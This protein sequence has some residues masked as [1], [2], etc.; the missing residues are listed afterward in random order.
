ML[1]QH[2]HQLRVGDPCMRQFIG[3]HS[4][5]HNG[6]GSASQADEYFVH[7]VTG[8]S[9]STR[10][11]STLRAC[12]RVARTSAIPPITSRYDSARMSEILRSSPKAEGETSCAGAP[13]PATAPRQ[14]SRRASK[15]PGFSFRARTTLQDSCAELPTAPA[16]LAQFRFQDGCRRSCLELCSGA[17]QCSQLLM[18]A[19]H[20][21]C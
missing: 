1:C 19:S 7:S 3:S 16:A 13:A 12:K 2:T 6:L 15:A 10:N 11:Y 21:S 5:I 8:S 20:V 4:K 18:H 14:S 9:G 17:D